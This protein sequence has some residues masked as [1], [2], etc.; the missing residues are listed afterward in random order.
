MNA[1]DDSPW[2]G[3]A[4]AFQSV[5]ALSEADELNWLIASGQPA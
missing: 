4:P 3:L 2:P 1:I 5:A